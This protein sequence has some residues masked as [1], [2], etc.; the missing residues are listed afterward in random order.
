[1]KHDVREEA[2]ATVVALQGDI[3][4]STSPQAR[5]L[6]LDQIKKGKAVLVDMGGVSYI[7]SSGVASL[8]EAL[9][10]ARKNKIDF[11]LAG[12]SPAAMRVLSLARLDQVFAI[13][14]SVED[15]LANA[16]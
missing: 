8:V 2:A 5:S 1:M 6:L 7:D 13:H 9:Q 11:R 3:D 10:G 4:L 12:V 14:D 16:G 15:A